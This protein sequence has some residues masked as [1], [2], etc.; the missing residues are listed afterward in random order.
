MNDTASSALAMRAC[1]YKIKSHR[2]VVTSKGSDLLKTPQKRWDCFLQKGKGRA[3]LVKAIP[4]LLRLLVARAR[5][6]NYLI[7]KEQEGVLGHRPDMG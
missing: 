5:N 2:L 3:L 7:A 4:L 6:R 1:S